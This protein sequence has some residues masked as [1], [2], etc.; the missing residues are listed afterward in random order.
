MERVVPNVRDFALGADASGSLQDG[1]SFRFVGGFSEPLAARVFC[2][3]ERAS[4]DETVLSFKAS[5]MSLSRCDMPS[6]FF[7]GAVCDCDHGIAEGSEPLYRE[8]WLD[9]GMLLDE[10]S[11]LTARRPEMGCF[12]FCMGYAALARVKPVVNASK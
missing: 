5:W 12:L 3:E 10:K 6:I 2:E 7:R 11:R 8:S 9:V 1:G 4:S